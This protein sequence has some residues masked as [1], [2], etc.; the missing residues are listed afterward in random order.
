MLHR[1]ALLRL[2]QQVIVPL[3]RLL[4]RIAL[5]LR[6]TLLVVRHTAPLQPLTLHIVLP[7][8]LLHLIAQ[9]PHLLPRKAL[10]LRITLP[11]LHRMVRLK[12]QR[13]RITLLTQHLFIRTDRVRFDTRHVTAKVHGIGTYLVG[14]M[15]I[16]TLVPIRGQVQ[17]LTPQVL[18]M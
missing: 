12:V 5:P 3:L 6:L 11:K 1:K 16:L 7:Q 9:Q 18:P 17:G 10:Q 8:R 2:S 15:P 13:L 14:V 4:L